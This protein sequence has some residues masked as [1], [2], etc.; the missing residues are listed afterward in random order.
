MDGLDRS[1]NLEHP[2]DSCDNGLFQ[3]II[4]AAIFGEGVE[5]H[6]LDPSKIKFVRRS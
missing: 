4:G 5:P 1:S 3:L 6:S 2:A